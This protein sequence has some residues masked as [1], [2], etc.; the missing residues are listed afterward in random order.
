MGLPGVVVNMLMPIGL[1]GDL[2]AS[3]AHREGFDL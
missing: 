1:G 2:I 3:S